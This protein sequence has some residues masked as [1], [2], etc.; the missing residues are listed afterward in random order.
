MTEPNPEK[1]FN[2]EGNPNVYIY[3]RVSTASQDIN[4]Q[5]ESCF[6]YCCKNNILPPLKNIYYDKGISGSKDFNEREIKNLKHLK[7]GDILVVPE[8]S[9]IGRDFINT[10]HYLDLVIPKGC[11]IKE[12]K[13]DFTL[14]ND[15]DMNDRLKMMFSCMTAEIER[16]NIKKRTLTAMQ[17]DSV[18]SKI[19]NKLD[20][21]F[22]L[23]KKKVEEGLNP[24][25]ISQL[26]EINCNK[27]QMYAFCRKHKFIE[28]K[29]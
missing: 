13:G 21:H 29:K 6:N 7:K 17:S 24:N 8:L 20:K 5:F 4:K 12:I 14:S 2:N 23:I 18:K 28:D 27:A 16:D 10:C 3:C 15:M 26:P 25:Q 9:R 11:L 22:D 19:S 1:Y